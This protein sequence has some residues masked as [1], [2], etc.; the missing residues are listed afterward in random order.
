MWTGRGPAQPLPHSLALIGLPSP[1]RTAPV[2]FRAL[3]F[4]PKEVSLWEWVAPAGGQL[5]MGQ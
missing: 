1:P 5:F 3:V 2:L 4:V